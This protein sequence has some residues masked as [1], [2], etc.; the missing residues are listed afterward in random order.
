M[1]FAPFVKLI[2]V[3]DSMLAESDKLIFGQWAYPSLSLSIG[4]LHF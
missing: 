3:L 4:R 2:G 1:S